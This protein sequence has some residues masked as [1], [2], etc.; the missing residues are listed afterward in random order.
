MRNMVVKHPGVFSLIP[1][2]VIGNI[3]ATAEAPALSCGFRAGVCQ[4]NVDDREQGLYE[5]WRWIHG[6]TVS[7][8]C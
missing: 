2:F 8:F 4:W 1:V 6:P 7:F 5:S 3:T